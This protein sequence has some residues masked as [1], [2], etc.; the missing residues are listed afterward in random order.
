MMRDMRR[1]KQQISKEAC[2]ALLKEETRGVLSMLGD[3]DYPYGVPMNHVYDGEGHL[4]FHCAKEGHK[5]DAIKA[6]PKVSYCVHD[7]G[8]KYGDDWFYTV[9][10]VVVFGTITEITDDEHR[11]AILHQLAHKFPVAEE[12]VERMITRSFPRVTCLKLTIEH[13]T[14]KRVK[15]A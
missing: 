12:E 11:K 14:G 8:V 15:E 7:A 3:D 9:N 1:K 2:M 10:S 5:Y 13:M 4:Y 6:H